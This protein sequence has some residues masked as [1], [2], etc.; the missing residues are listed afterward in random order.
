MHS[1]KEKTIL[2]QKKNKPS[3][4][5]CGNTLWKGAHKRVPTFWKKH[6]PNT[7][8]RI[9]VSL[10]SKRFG[11]GVEEY[12]EFPKGLGR[13]ALHFHTD[14]A[15]SN[16]WGGGVWR[17]GGN[18]ELQVVGRAWADWRKSKTGTAGEGLGAALEG[19]L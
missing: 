13:V 1:L 2:Y 4:A 7:N 11:A 17:A 10:H 18:T 9:W 12:E 15:K 14:K 16:G 5:K 19:G 8:T 6:K 3:N